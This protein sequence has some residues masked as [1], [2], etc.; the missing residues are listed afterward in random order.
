MD[1]NRCEMPT[2]Y[3]CPLCRSFDVVWDA[4]AVWDPTMQQ[5]ALANVMDKGHACNDCGEEITPEEVVITPGQE[6]L[7]A[8]VSLEAGDLS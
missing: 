8:L 6:T 2:T 3:R 5:Y 7:D 4:T 1:V